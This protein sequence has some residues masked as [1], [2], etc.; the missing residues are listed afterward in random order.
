M[1]PS[2]SASKHQQSGRLPICWPNCTLS[3]KYQRMPLPCLPPGLFIRVPAG[4]RMNN[5]YIRGDNAHLPTSDRHHSKVIPRYVLGTN[6]IR[7][8]CKRLFQI[9]LNYGK[10]GL[11]SQG[12]FPSVEWS[13]VPCRRIDEVD[14]LDSHARASLRHFTSENR[15]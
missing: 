3:T 13:L 9:L 2:P 1:L 12:R 5:D 15:D 4:R 8:T 14:S 10:L 6:T 7:N 11:L